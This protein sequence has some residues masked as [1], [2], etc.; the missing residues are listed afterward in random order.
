MKCTVATRE[1]YNSHF[2]TKLL[3]HLYLHICYVPQEPVSRQVSIS[4][5]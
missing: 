2:P 3:P 1:Q 4:D 5:R